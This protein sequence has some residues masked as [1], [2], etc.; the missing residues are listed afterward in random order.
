M[1]LREVLDRP[2]TL[3]AWNGVPVVGQIAKGGDAMAGAA[4][5]L[6]DGR[7]LYNRQFRKLEAPF[8]RK[9]TPAT[10]RE[11]EPRS[12]LGTS[13]GATKLLPKQSDERNV[14]QAWYRK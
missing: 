3:F 1:L 2:G 6:S 8:V 12:Y 11:I 9:L 7:K 14:G 13:Q 10:Q 5:D 4:T